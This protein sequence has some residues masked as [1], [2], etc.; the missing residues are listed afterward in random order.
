MDKPLPINPL[1]D[2]H[3]IQIRRSL[4]IADQA[5]QAIDM[6]ERAGIDVSAT[7]AQLQDSKQKLLQ[8]KNVYFPN[9]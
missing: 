8:I 2:N 1:T 6:A 7:K 9:T 5:L 3:L 4:D